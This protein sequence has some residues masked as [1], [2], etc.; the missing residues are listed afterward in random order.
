MMP[1]HRKSSAYKHRVSESHARLRMSSR[2]FSN[3]EPQKKR[4]SYCGIAHVLKNDTPFQCKIVFMILMPHERAT[5][6][7]NFGAAL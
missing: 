7:R 2:G 5:P 4:H 3:K 6:F 1:I